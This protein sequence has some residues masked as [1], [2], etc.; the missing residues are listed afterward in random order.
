MSI[1]DSGDTTELVRL[2]HHEK[3][4]HNGRMLESGRVLLNDSTT[5]RIRVFENG[6]EVTSIHVAGTWLR[7]MVVLDDSRVLVGTAPASVV[8]IDLDAGTELQRVTLSENRL[9]ALHGLT[10]APN[11]HGP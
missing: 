8:L 2:D 5:N 7:G 1:P 10:L 3:P 9:E 11:G 6:R 4:T